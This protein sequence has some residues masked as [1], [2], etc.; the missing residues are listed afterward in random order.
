[1]KSPVKW[2]GAKGRASTLARLL[3]LVPDSIDCY[4]EPFFGSGALFFE[5]AS[6]RKI[7][8]ALL[9][10]LNPHLIAMW[11]GVKDSPHHVV[12]WLKFYESLDGGEIF[13]G[14]RRKFNVGPEAFPEPG[15][16]AAA[17]IYLN[18]AGY[19]GLYR[20][21]AKGE[22]NAPYSAKRKIGQI[23][24]EEAIFGTS[25]LLREVDATLL[26]LDFMRT[27]ES[28]GAG[29]FI[30]C[31]PPYAGTF[32]DYACPRFEME[33]H[34]RLR[35]S[36]GMAEARGARF[37]VS[38]STVEEVLKMYDGYNFYKSERSNAVNANGADRSAKPDLII[39]NYVSA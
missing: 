29:D 24:F 9:A 30:Y 14:V 32:S 22:F 26:H 17:F 21:N 19:N 31:D 3:S 15:A 25:N 28:A 33:D 6:R 27:V 8:S 34:E 39:T 23:V 12:H 1:M 35:D 7:R 18:R 37:M 13:H 20:V 16:F 36:L 4:Y 5:L 38:N 2:V 10:D 11:Q